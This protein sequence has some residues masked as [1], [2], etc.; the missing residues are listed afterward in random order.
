MATNG[1]TQHV[2]DEVHI[3]KGVRPV[4]QHGWVTV[5]D[6][7]LHLLGTDRHVIASA[8]V[9]RVRA[10][11]VRFSGGKTLAMKIDGTRYNVSPKWGERTGPIMRPGPADPQRAA[12]ATDE[13]LRV[14]EAR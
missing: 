3:G 9:E 4:A 2:F 1:K 5:T 11:K 14:I 7:V 6:G 8:P 13:L 12:R 10:S